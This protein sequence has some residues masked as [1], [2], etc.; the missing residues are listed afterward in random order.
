MS[1]RIFPILLVFFAILA[2]AA[3]LA[4]LHVRSQQ[5]VVVF[6][7]E[8]KVSADAASPPP[9]SSSL[10]AKAASAPLPGKPPAE[11]GFIPRAGEVLEFSADVAKVNNVAT[12]RLEVGGT[13]ALRGKDVWHL[14]A[15]AHTQNPL[16][17]VFALDDQFDSYSD[18]GSF[19]SMQYEMRLNERGQKVD[20]IQRM[21]TTAKEPAPPGASIARVLPGTRDPLGFM[22]YLRSVDWSKTAEVRSPVYDGRKLYEVRAERT[23]AAQVNVVAGD[24]STNTIEIRVFENG[25]EMKDAHFMLYLTKDLSRTPVL[26]EA[27]LPFATARVELVK[28]TE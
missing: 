11:P 27:V 8:P 28:C 14:Q 24:F 7:P 13:T 3:A 20:S 21:S 15:S 18:A 16:R 19:V 25:A 12:L 17:M 4:W 9:A 5:P 23:G 22:Q 1:R 2:V 10:P 6:T 26:L